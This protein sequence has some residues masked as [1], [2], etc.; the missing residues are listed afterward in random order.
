MKYNYNVSME[1]DDQK[2]DEELYHIDMAI[3]NIIITFVTEYLC[4][5]VSKVTVKLVKGED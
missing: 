1:I 4:E 3:K 2:T 5:D